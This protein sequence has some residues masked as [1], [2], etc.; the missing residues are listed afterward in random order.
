MF[1]WLFVLPANKFRLHVSTVSRGE[2]KQRVLVFRDYTVTLLCRQ[3][4]LVFF[5]PLIQFLNARIAKKIFIPALG[6]YEA[7]SG[8]QPKIFK[9]T[10]NFIVSK[11]FFCLLT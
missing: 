8:L 3:F 5:S 7:A 9:Y 1:F 2:G 11:G 10:P 4:L 6:F